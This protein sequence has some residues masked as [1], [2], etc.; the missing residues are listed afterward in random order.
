MVY[1]GISLVNNRHRRTE[2]W[3]PKRAFFLAGSAVPSVS[4]TESALFS[5]I[6]L[7][8]EKKKF[9]LLLYPKLLSSFHSCGWV[10]WHCL[11]SLLVASQFSS[12]PRRITLDPSL[13]SPPCA[14]AQ[15]NFECPWEK[16]L[17][18]NDLLH[19]ISF[20]AFDFHHIWEKHCNNEISSSPVSLFQN[21]ALER[22]PVN[23]IWRTTQISLTNYGLRLNMNRRSIQPL[24]VT[25]YLPI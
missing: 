21:G 20:F 18:I 8:S 15:K 1:I 23:R 17:G 2:F 3:I 24:L 4:S 7:A 11:I 16:Y 22:L 13:S 5:N 12:V 10:R 9:F 6:L 25:S 19:P 14:C